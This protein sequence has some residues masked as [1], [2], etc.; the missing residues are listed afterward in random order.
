M[1]REYL[2]N[3]SDQIF[4]NLK[5]FVSSPNSVHNVGEEREKWVP[6]PKANSITDL[7]NYYKIGAMLALT[8][9][10]HECVELSMPSI[11]WQYMFSRLN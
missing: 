3:S 5:L 10:I 7:E 4:N 8:L 6:N 11:F 2:A 1:R 9:R